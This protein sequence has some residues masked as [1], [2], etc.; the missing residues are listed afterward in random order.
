MFFFARIDFAVRSGDKHF[1]GTGWRLA[2]KNLDDDVLRLSKTECTTAEAGESCEVVV[3]LSQW[4]EHFVSLSVNVSN[5]NAA[6]GNLSST[7]FVFSAS[8]WDT[9]QL[10]TITGVD[11]YVDDGDITY[12]VSMSVLLSYNVSSV[13]ESKSVEGSS[14]TVTNTA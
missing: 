14:V 8:D 13:I 7:I 11:D 12:E 1:N 5:G 9:P 10:L 3:S 2:A 6:E 4:Q